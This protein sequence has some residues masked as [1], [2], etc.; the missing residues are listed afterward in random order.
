[1]KAPRWLFP[2]IAGLILGITILGILSRI[3][4]RVVAHATDATP[5]FSWGGSFT[6]VFLGAAWG[7]GG[8]VIHAVLLRLLPHRSAARI[9]IFAFALVL[10]TLRG[11]RPFTPLTLALFMPLSLAY[12]ALL[13]M[14]HRRWRVP[15]DGPDA[16][17][18]PTPSSGRTSTRPTGRAE[19]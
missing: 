19:H 15:N 6:V 1:M 14:A 2:P 13:V 10:L 12:G 11:L 5:G 18:A 3:A 17:P 7:V 4:M 9:V 16:H 8:A